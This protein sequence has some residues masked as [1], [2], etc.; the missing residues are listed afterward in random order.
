MKRIYSSPNSA[1]IGLL[2]DRLKEAGI[3]CVLQN[4]NVSQT[5][6][7]PAFSADLFVV[8]DE[9]YEKAISLCE[10]WRHPSFGSRQP[11]TCPK[12]GELHEGQ[13]NAC[14]RCGTTRDGDV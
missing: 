2:H 10:A 14:W 1:E 5:I 3:P 6:P 12:C 11:W 8:N 7:L 9:D 13:F 4:E